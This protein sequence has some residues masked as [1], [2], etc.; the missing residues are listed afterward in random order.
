MFNGSN[1]DQKSQLSEI[2]TEPLNPLNH[3]VDRFPKCLAGF[4]SPKPSRNE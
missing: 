1:S 2:M 4:M 3:L